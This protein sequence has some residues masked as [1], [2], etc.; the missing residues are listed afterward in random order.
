VQIPRIDSKNALGLV[1]KVVG[2]GKEVVGNLTGSKRLTKAGEVQ[3]D[4]GTERIKA[5]RAEANAKKEEAK[6]AAA[7]QAQ[8]GA[9]RRKES[10][11]N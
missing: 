8:R 5:V 6:G 3:Q 9:Q 10:V 4:K 11:K 1:S 2:L 7:E